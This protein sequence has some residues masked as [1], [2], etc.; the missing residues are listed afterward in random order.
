MLYEA[1]TSLPLLDR[2]DTY[3]G[4]ISSYFVEDASYFRFRNMVVG[5]TIPGNMVSKLSLTK[6]RFYVQAQNLFT[7][8]KYTGL[9]PDI[10]VLNYQGN[11]ARRDLSTGLDVGRYPLS[12]QFIVGLN[13]EF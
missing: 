6:A 13:I 5:Y 8:T 3:S 12:K 10:T 7:I 2:S 1:G 9:D 4:R 11:Q